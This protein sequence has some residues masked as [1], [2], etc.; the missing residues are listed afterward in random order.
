MEGILYHKLSRISKYHTCQAK[1]MMLF[2]YSGSK[3]LVK[4]LN[5]SRK[6]VLK[7]NIL[8]H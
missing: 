4:L 5:K 8:G 3:V 2:K 1:L 7:A 6:Q